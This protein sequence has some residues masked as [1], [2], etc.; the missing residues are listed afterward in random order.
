MGPA[1]F[2]DFTHHIRAVGLGGIVGHCNKQHSHA[3]GHS[4][5][6]T[7][8]PDRRSETAKCWQILDA[9]S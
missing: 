5:P 4:G 9:P 6:L 8:T 3:R 2:E 7:I 1:C